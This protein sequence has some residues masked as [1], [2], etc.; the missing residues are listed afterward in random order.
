[1]SKLIILIGLIFVGCYLDTGNLINDT[2]HYTGK[3]LSNNSL[4]KGDKV[5]LAT[6]VDINNL[7][8]T[9]QFGR[10]I[11]EQVAR[12][13]INDGYKVVDVRANLNGIV[14]GKR[15]GEFYITRDV[16]KLANSIKANAIFYG[17]YSVGK[18]FVYVN[19]KLINAKHHII[20][21]SIDY[22]IHL[23]DDVKKMLGLKKKINSLKTSQEAF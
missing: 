7:D 13:F 18:Q 6:V 12:E 11:T 19:L 3:L 17:T 2:Y 20:L 4:K 21:N 22:R 5:V 1:M 10:T 14:V 8:D 9:T 15:K 16:E 23:N